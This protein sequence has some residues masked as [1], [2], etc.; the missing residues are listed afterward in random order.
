V[1]NRENDTQARKEPFGSVI[2][3]KQHASANARRGR[4]SPIKQLKIAPM[5]SISRARHGQ[6]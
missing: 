4:L 3:R 6:V 5:V 2:R 1:K